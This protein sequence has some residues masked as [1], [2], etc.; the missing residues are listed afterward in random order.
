MGIA[1]RGSILGGCCMYT[2]S[3]ILWKNMA[4]LIWGQ[5][6]FSSLGRPLISTP[7]SSPSPSPRSAPNTSFDVCKRCLTKFLCEKHDLPRRR[8]KRQSASL[9]FWFLLLLCSEAVCHFYG[10]EPLFFLLSQ[11]FHIPFKLTRWLF[12]HF[13]WF[14]AVCQH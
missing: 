2:C 10:C 4:L 11:P 5:I 12:L 6:V 14:N 9:L 8:D 1:M 13:W 7:I 3:D